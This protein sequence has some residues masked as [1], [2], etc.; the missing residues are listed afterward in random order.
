[1]EFLQANWF[2]IVMLAII[3]IERAVSHG[4]A[5]AKVQEIGKKIDELEKTVLLTS[6]RFAVHS[7]DSNVHITP[8][9]TELFRERNDYMKKELEDTRRDVRRVEQMLT[10]M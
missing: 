5:K 1:M 8:T 9:L 3:V 7:T 2:S 4:M 6:E 10:K